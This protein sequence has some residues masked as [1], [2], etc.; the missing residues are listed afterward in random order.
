MIPALARFVEEL[1]REGVDASP[2]ELLDAA[3][4][5]EAVGLEHRGRFKAALRATLAKDRRQ[6]RVFDPLFERFFAPPRRVGD[7]KGDRAGATG[8]GGPRRSGGAERVATAPRSEPRQA[9]SRRLAEKEPDRARPNTESDREAVR[10]ALEAARRKGPGREGRLRRARDE[11]QE[12]A[13][14]P[15]ER[16][17]T[18]ETDPLRRDLTRPMPTEEERRLARLVPR[19]VEE[20]RIRRGRRLRRAHSGR[21]W[22]RKAF[23]ENL[24]RGGV[25]F[26][27]PLRRQRPRRPRVVLLVD[28]SYST[29]RASGYFLWMAAE[30]LKLG[31]QAR[32]VAFVDRPV[33]ATEAVARWLRGRGAAGVES[34]TDRASRVLGSAAGGRRGRRPGGGIGP[35]SSS[36]ASLLEA[37]PGLNL[38]APSDYGRA[39]HG[40]LRSHLRPAGR[41]TVLL[42][43]GDGR[44]NRFDPLPWA[45]EEIAGRCRA[46]LWLV[47][48]PSSRWGSGDSAL[49]SYL[50]SVDTVVE[51]K[52][53]AGL[54][55]GLQELLRRLG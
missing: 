3:R 48:E 30:F 19:L 52:D 2:A 13:R 50:P 28:V 10:R 26:V 17:S 4:A 47:P 8:A 16:G 21:P 44:T 11:R 9:G 54:A 20:V 43:L 40:L 39:L 6:T 49:A 55:R 35:A 33:D 23:R 36:F 12:D 15:R 31:R 1:R 5:L 25:P 37:L 53:L 38:E 24:S 34:G 46:V 42:I 22:A 29:A 14:K 41:D 51:A 45:L 18:D 32:V 27:I 7:G